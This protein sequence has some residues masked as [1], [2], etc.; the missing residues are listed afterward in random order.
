MTDNQALVTRFI[1]EAWNAPDLAWH[2]Q[3]Y[4]DEL[5]GGLIDDGY[6]PGYWRTL[7]WG[8]RPSE[9]RT[10]A[11]WL[12]SQI[13]PYRLEYPDFELTIDRM[14]VD[15]DDVV[16]ELSFRGEHATRRFVD[17]G[18]NERPAQHLA[19]GIGWT[20]VG[21]DGIVRHGFF[22]EGGNFL[23]RDH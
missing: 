23:G 10:A 11:E 19:R 22:W 15:G 16:S 14:I 7:H 4:I 9:E 20:R 2:D 17:R 5:L 8:W 13:E 3:A 6:R 1:T 21:D 18:G 12:R